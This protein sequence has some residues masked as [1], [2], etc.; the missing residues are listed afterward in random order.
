VEKRAAVQGD[1]PRQHSRTGA[2][3]GL[4][5]RASR[6]RSRSASARAAFISYLR[7][8][9][10][11]DVK[12]ARRDARTLARAVV[13]TGALAIVACTGAGVATP[14]DEQAA[15]DRDD[16]LAL[17]R[18]VEVV[19]GVVR[20]SAWLRR[21]VADPLRSAPPSLPPTTASLVIVIRAGTDTA[22]VEAR[23]RGAAT[24]ALAS[25]GGPT[26]V[27]D[28]LVAPTPPPPPALVRAGPFTVEAGS[29]RPLLATLAVGLIAIAGLAS[30]IVLL[31][32]RRRRDDDA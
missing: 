25:A 22:D 9:V 11:T 6:R 5:R 1:L 26:P 27:I 14:G 31:E 18:H 16:A 17:A 10:A 2:A 12:R 3:S 32:L 28:V 30:W 7:G 4:G 23:V 29:R 15:R 8:A 20:A 24:A 13:V 19:P 21:P